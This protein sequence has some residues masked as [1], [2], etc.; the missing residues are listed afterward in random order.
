MLEKTIYAGMS[1]F[2]LVFILIIGFCFASINEIYTKALH[3][4]ENAKEL[5]ESL[6]KSLA[7]KQAKLDELNKEIDLKK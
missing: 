5:N 1:I 7:L 6:A 3:D 2:F 4:Y